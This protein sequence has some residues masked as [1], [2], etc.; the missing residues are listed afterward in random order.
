M[1]NVARL[2]GEK[3]LLKSRERDAVCR[4]LIEPSRVACLLVRRQ[5]RWKLRDRVFMMRQRYKRKKNVSVPTKTWQDKVLKT[6]PSHFAGT[7][8]SAEAWASPMWGEVAD[9]ASR[10]P[11]SVYGSAP[12]SSVIPRS[13]KQPCSVINYRDVFILHRQGIH[14][15][16]SSF[17][18]PQS[19]TRFLI[20]SLNFQRARLFTEANSTVV[21]LS[22]FLHM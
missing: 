7:W 22:V 21:R 14:N 19:F 20:L 6:S 8:T 11:L 12:P 9:A 4:Q 1:V 15:F 3:L 10:R 18:V 5:A 17:R 16:I 2:K 13:A